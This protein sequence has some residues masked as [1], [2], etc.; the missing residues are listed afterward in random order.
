ML[1]RRNI[2]SRALVILN[3]NSD[4]ERAVKWVRSAPTGTRVEFKHSRRS[5]PQNAKMWASLSDIAS[6]VKWHGVKLSAEDWK[7]VFLNSLKKELR[8]VPNLD[9]DGF[10]QLGRS[11]SD[12][13]KTEMSDLIELIHMF[14]AKHEVK[15]HEPSDAATLQGAEG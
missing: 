6:Q 1:V 14:G 12:L 9:G 7:L 8:I 11:S 13:S 3:G 10:V 5:L 4:R 15:F 2:M